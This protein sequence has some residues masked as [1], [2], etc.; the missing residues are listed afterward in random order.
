M[1]FEDGCTLAVTGV[2]SLQS[3][4]DHGKIEQ[5]MD[6]LINGASGGIGTYA[7]QIAKILGAKVTGVCSS[8]NVK[9]V[10]SL[11]ADK[12][13]DYTQQ[14]WSRMSDKFDIILDAVGNK[15][16]SQAKNNLKKNGIIVKL[17]ITPKN[18]M[19]QYILSLFSSKKA[20]MVLLKNRKEDVKW[21]RD[22]IAIGRIKVIHDKSFRL[23]DVRKA[24]LY[25]ETE[26]ARGKII[27]KP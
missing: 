5:G 4:R 22:Q 8:R 3:L 26:R 1:S 11:G 15:S 12:V 2:T 24:H 9:L 19:E 18:L 20:K 17:N 25:S 16:F 6:V 23:E 10:K 21:V 7:V 27:L 13:I 14:N